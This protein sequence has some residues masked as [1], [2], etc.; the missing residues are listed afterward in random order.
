MKKGG[1]RLI[2]GENGEAL[3]AYQLLFAGEK[4]PD[5]EFRE[6]FLNSAASFLKLPQFEGYANLIYDPFD[7]L[8]YLIWRIKDDEMRELGAVPGATVAGVENV[9]IKPVEQ[10]DLILKLK[11]KYDLDVGIAGRKELLAVAADL[12]AGLQEQLNCLEENYFSGQ[13]EGGQSAYLLQAEGPLMFLGALNLW[14]NIGAR[15]EDL[16]HHLDNLKFSMQVFSAPMG[17]NHL[18]IERDNIAFFNACTSL[19]QLLFVL[20]NGDNKDSQRDFGAVLD[21]LGVYPGY[22]HQYSHGVKL[23]VGTD[24][25]FQLHPVASVEKYLISL[26]KKAIQNFCHLAVKKTERKGEQHQHD[27]PE[28]NSVE[29]DRGKFL[30]GKLLAVIGTLL[31]CRLVEEAEE[32]VR[33]YQLVNNQIEFDEYN[34]RETHYKNWYEQRLNLKKNLQIA[35]KQQFKGED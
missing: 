13:D 26:K 21:D 28:V 4:E 32:L 7:Q 9:Q 1:L 30:S 18:I 35:R 20:Q 33:I 22:H 2:D 23:I 29:V 12:I 14:Q 8:T 31:N 6:S 11:N 15:L 24:P 3:S 17:V 25:D 34:T 5:S 10:D 19:S 16:R 27:S